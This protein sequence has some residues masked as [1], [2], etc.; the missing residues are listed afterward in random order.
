VDRRKLKKIPYLVL[1]KEKRI[2]GKGDPGESDFPRSWT[3]RPKH[4]GREK[5]SK[6]KE[7]CIHYSRPSTSRG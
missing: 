7:S 4:G 1:L 6:R 3:E 2:E 5:G